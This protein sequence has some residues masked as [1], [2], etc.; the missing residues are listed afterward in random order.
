MVAIWQFELVLFGGP[1]AQSNDNQQTSDRPLKDPVGGEPKLAGNNRPEEASLKST[2]RKDDEEGHRHKNGMGG[3]NLLTRC[4][5]D[6]SIVA[7]SRVGARRRNCG[8]RVG[9]WLVKGRRQLIG[10]IEGHGSLVVV[11]DNGSIRAVA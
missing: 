6:R 7:G 10:E 9:S 11:L 8:R 3:K 5:G 2:E 1:E 4:E